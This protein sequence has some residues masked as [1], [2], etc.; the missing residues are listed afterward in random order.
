MDKSIK[1]DIITVLSR[2]SDKIFKHDL[3]EV[4]LG[5]EIAPADIILVCSNENDKFDPIGY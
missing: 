3:T 5:S 2:K 4:P 1:D